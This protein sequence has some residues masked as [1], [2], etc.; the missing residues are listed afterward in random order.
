MTEIPPYVRAFAHKHKVDLDK[1]KPDD[2]GEVSMFSVAEYAKERL[3]GDLY[4]QAV[5]AQFNLNAGKSW[6]GRTSSTTPVRS[7]AVKTN[8]YALNPLADRVRA[9]RRSN[10]RWATAAPTLFATGDLPAFTASGIPVDSLLQVPW[11]ARHAMAA[12]PTP[13]EAYSILSECQGEDAELTAR[14]RG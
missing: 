12:A 1:L 8:A 9:E 6:D 3:D 10:G 2:S 7:E 13:A 5:I 11:S 14:V 4:A